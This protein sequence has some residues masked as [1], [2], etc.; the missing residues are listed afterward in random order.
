LLVEG[1]P[2]TIANVSV[3]PPVF[4]ARSTDLPRFVTA[5]PTDLGHVTDVS[6]FR[7]GYGHSYTGDFE[8]CRS[9]K[10]YFGTA[11]GSNDIHEPQ[12]APVSGTI[13]RWEEEGGPSDV[14]MTIRPDGHPA[15]GVEMFHVDPAAGLQRGTHVD[16]G[17]KLGA[18]AED[19]WTAS[20]PSVIA[21]T[22]QGKT[23]V[24][25]FA[26]MTDDAFAEYT[27]YG[28]SARE[29]LILAEEYRDANP[30]SCEQDGHGTGPFTEQIGDRGLSDVNFVELEH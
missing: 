12:Y 10:H 9:M 20:E 4:A 29:E 28:I 15:F 25:L 26:V 11:G 2:S 22:P 21:F 6:Y 8:T 17:Q 16:A 19:T 3:N 13:F 30:I 7:S 24:S 27:Q 23:Y 1:A 5:Q 18:M 14:M